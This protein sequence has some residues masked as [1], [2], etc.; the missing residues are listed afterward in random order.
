M[1]YHLMH[2]FTTAIVYHSSGVGATG[3]WGSCLPPPPNFVTGGGACPHTLT[4]KIIY[5]SVLAT[6]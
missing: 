3:Q 5:K 4:N 2:R 1:E 6:N